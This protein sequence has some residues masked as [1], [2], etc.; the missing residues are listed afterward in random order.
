MRRVNR[1]VFALIPSVLLFSGSLVHQLDAAL[2]KWLHRLVSST[3]Q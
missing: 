3:L 2:N 1:A